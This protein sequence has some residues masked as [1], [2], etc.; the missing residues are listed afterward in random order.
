MSRINHGDTEGRRVLVYRG[1]AE[2]LVFQLR[3]FHEASQTDLG[4]ALRQ[5]SRSLTLRFRDVLGGEDWR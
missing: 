2:L 5:R 3:L 1:G 4:S